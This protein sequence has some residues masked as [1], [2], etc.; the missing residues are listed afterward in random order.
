MKK[1][2]GL[3]PCAVICVAMVVAAQPAFAQG[4]DFAGSWTLDAEKTTRKDGPAMVIIALTDKELTVKFGPT[5][6][7]MPFNLDGSERVVKEKGATTRA[8][9][10]ATSSKRR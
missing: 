1:L 6:P 3:L 2:T 9:W 7:V 10:K 5:A 8:A 4:R